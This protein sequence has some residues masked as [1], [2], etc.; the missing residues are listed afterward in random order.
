ML[1]I[2]N[3]AE[4]N[5]ILIAMGSNLAGH[6]DSPIAQLD[7]AIREMPM[8]SIRI[9]AKS[10]YFRTPCFP[11]G[12]GPDFVNSAIVCACDLGPQA[13][14]DILHRIEEAAG[15]AR[16]AR[17]QARVLDLDL[18]AIGKNVLPDLPT[19]RH[20]ADLSLA[21]QMHDAPP[22]L[23]LPH[24]R[25]QERAFVLHP[26]MDIAPDWVHPVTGQSVRS[27]HAALDPQELAQITP[28]SR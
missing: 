20:W 17:W 11:A 8:N 13:I 28:I 6:S 10:R 19:Y 16:K 25:L 5:P 24:P 9:V 7:Y 14:L 27:M 1:N 3:E 4:F 12:A 26:L 22:E 18:L 2:L 23:I 21:R 15:R